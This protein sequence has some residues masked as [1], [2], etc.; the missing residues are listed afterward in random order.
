MKGIIDDEERCVLLRDIDALQ[1]TGRGEAD[2]VRSTG[3]EENP[4]LW[5]MI[6]EEVGEEGGEEES[7]EEG[8]QRSEGVRP[9]VPNYTTLAGR[10]SQGRLYRH[11]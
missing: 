5:R 9:Q 7:E 2:L 6:L 3:S 1:T 10:R 8:N 11:D 4:D